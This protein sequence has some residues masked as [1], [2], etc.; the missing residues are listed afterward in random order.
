MLRQTTL[1]AVL[2]VTCLTGNAMA[3]AMSNQTEQMSPPAKMITTAK[4]NAFVNAHGMTLYTYDKDPAGQATCNAACAKN[5]PP[6]LAPASAM[7]AGN[8]SIVTR[9]D[10]AKQWAYKGKPLYTWSKDTKPGETSGDGFKMVW[11]VA[12]P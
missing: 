7:A 12:Q 3:Q 8:W 2:F 10:G 6:F 5:W 11:H 9:T 1:M 4:G